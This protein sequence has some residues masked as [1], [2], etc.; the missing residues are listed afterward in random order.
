MSNAWRGAGLTRC[1]SDRP[2][3]RPTTHVRRCATCPLS[4]ESLVGTEIKF[5]GLT[6]PEDA[7]A[8]VALG[9]RY[10][11]VIFAGGPRL[12]TRDR[13]AEVLAE[14]P[15]SVSRVGV[16]SD[17][18]ASEIA[19]AARVL[20]LEV[21]QL[22]AGF[23][24]ERIAALR[25]VFEGEIW[26]V[27]R[28]QGSTL[29]ESFR[30]LC[31]WSDAVLLDAFVPGAL[32]GTGRTLDWPALAGAVGIAL[33][34]GAD[35]ARVVLAGGLRPENVAQAIAALSPA[36]VDVSSGVESIAGIKDHDRMRA[37]RDAVSHASIPT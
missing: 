36:V 12:L 1:S 19:N 14:V 8:A 11:G 5:C 34:R 7:N 21:V 22:H 18:G 35:A 20:G 4:L 25:E 3:R 33:G 30:D 13:A 28:V 24:S 27:C 26:S 37:F 17:Q 6:R 15:R 16:F 23:D 31:T 10:V 9:A 32:G 29:P 2:S